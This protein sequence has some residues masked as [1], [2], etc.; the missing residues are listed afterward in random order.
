MNVLLPGG[1]ALAHRLV[2]NA[3]SRSRRLVVLIDQ[4]ALRAA[5][6]AADGPVAVAL[7]LGAAAI[8]TED[9]RIVSNLAPL[10]WRANR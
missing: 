3:P 5:G 9:R 4:A 10:H 2:E 8:S 7:S 6:L 1:K